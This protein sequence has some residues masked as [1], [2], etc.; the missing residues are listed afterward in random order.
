MIRKER[1]YRQ[2]HKIIFLRIK[3]KFKYKIETPH[4]GKVGNSDCTD[5]L[6]LLNLFA[7]L[8]IEEAATPFLHDHVILLIPRRLDDTGNNNWRRLWELSK[9][10]HRR[11]ARAS[12][13]QLSS[14]PPPPVAP[15]I[16]IP[17]SNSSDTCAMTNNPVI[18]S[19][20]DQFLRWLQDIKKK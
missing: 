17:A 16:P 9:K 19:L 8:I 12:L 11:R 15:T 2:N 1:F 14:N 13:Q 10:S 4:K 6:H 20:E 7:D 18:Q 3:E 5:F